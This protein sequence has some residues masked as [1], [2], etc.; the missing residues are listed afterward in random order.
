VHAT[1]TDHAG[2]DGAEP[3]GVHTGKVVALA[4]VGALGGFLFGYDSSV[5]NGAN[6]ALYEFFGI[7]S[8]A[9]KGFV[10]SVALLGSAVGAF[11]GGGLAD[12]YGRKRVM[13][14]AALLFL[15]AGIGTAFPFGIPDFI[16]WRI[17]G[18]FAIGLA[19][20]ISPMYIAEI[21]PAHLRGRL[22]SLF[23]FAIVIGI[24]STQL[25]NEVIIGLAGGNASDDLGPLAAWRWMF[26]MMVVPAVVYGVLAA[27]LPESP[28]YLIAQG[29]D[30]EAEGVLRRIFIGDV[31]ATVASI[32]ASV[33]SD[34]KPRLSDLRARRGGLLPIV[35]IGIGLAV[36]Q[37]FVGINAVFY[38]SNLIWASVGF[39]QSAAFLTSTITSVVNVAFTVVAILLVDRIGRRPLL[40][41]GSAGMAVALGTLAL[42][43]T[44]ATKVTAGPGVAAATVGQPVLTDTTGPIAVVALNVFVAFFAATWGP[45]V[46]V[47]LGEIFP[48]AIRA[49]AL[50]VAV[51]ANWIANF[52]VSE[53]FPEL[54]AAS[55]GFAYWLFTLFAVLSLFY[56]LRFVRETKG[57]EL[58]E[59]DE[60]RVGVA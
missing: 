26:L 13:T 22:S 44:T 51:M 25:V 1:P 2:D 55:L 36:F 18:G 30:Q 56:V 24:F 20:V 35:W 49:A 4:I 15:I 43:F 27:R 42:V 8:A 21:A 39:D 3:E 19:A 9:L 40:L 38:Y 53:S 28:R 11:I 32:R 52:V 41:I 23:Q 37:Q 29:R 45:V 14:I 17:V 7:S 48:N 5:I 31:A 50:S 16:V 10:V 46:W 59:M 54:A 33:A 58:E 12:R 6:Q 60:E 47:L 57:T 34:H